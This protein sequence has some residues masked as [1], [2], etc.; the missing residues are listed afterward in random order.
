MNTAVT[1]DKC[2]SLLG[3]IITVHSFITLA[4]W[5]HTCL[6]Q[7]G[8]AYWAAFIMKENSDHF[9]LFWQGKVLVLKID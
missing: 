2:S 5:F 9:T 4:L 1:K 3:K 6:R 8:Q 7:L